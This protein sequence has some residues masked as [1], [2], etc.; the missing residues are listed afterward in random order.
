MHNQMT[1]VSANTTLFWKM[2]IPILYATFF[3]LLGLVIIFELGANFSLFTSLYV[4]VSYGLMFLALFGFMYFTI[5][6]L[7]RVEM[8]GEAFIATN[9]FKAYRYKIDDIKAYYTYDFFVFKIHSIH[10]KSKGKFG[11]K[12]RFIPYMV[13]LDIVKEQHQK[14]SELING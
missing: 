4:K 6:K 14:W 3:G 13:G 8:D 5:M 2:F 10:L 1:R 12:I 11:K 9:Y 7:K